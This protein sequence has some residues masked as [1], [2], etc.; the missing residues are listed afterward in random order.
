MV[1]CGAVCWV[2]G[3]GICIGSLY[4]IGSCPMDY[5]AGGAGF[6]LDCNFPCLIAAAVLTLLD[7]TLICC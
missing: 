1:L 3:E 6:S 5:A 4:A 2:G 7:V